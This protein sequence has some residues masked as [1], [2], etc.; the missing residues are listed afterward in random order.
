MFISQVTEAPNLDLGKQFFDEIVEFL[1]PQ[2]PDLTSLC[3]EFQL[4]TVSN[5]IL[6]WTEK[7][8][9]NGAPGKRE[10]TKMS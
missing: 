8:S 2:E 9:Q 5:G 6:T 10:A 3:H 1:D 4:Q 7:G